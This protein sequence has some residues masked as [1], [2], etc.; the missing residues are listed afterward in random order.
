MDIV[1]DVFAWMWEHRHTLQV[2]SV[3]AYLKAAVRFK[4]ANYIRSGRVR[5]TFFQELANYTPSNLPPGAEELAEARELQAII[6]RAIGQL[7]QKCQE[8]FRLSREER[9]SNQEI[10]KRLG[11][12]VKTVENQMTIALKR[13]RSK[14]EPLIGILLLVLFGS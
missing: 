7:P 4:M 5:D 14:V 3:K 11:V 6:Q 12:S 10:A 1:Q 9:L 8:I 2:V 13:L